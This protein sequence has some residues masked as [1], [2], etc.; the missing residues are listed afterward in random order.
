MRVFNLH[1]IEE[2]LYLENPIKEILN[3]EM[4]IETRKVNL[5]SKAVRVFL[6]PS[7]TIIILLFEAFILFLTR[8][9]LEGLVPSSTFR[10]N[11]ST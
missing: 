2:V 9:H 10:A 5:D 3:V 6:P 1:I 7:T 4:A 8:Y 11:I